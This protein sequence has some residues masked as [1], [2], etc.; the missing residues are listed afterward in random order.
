MNREL[1]KS[2]MVP[3]YSSG[4]DQLIEFMDESTDEE[5]EVLISHN[6][7]IGEAR[8]AVVFDGYQEFWLD[9]FLTQD[10]AITF[11]ARYDLT[12]Q[13]TVDHLQ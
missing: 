11:C 6:T 9:S 4:V 3:E 1:F 13:Q 2:E 7:D 5:L 10:E 8:W 12:V